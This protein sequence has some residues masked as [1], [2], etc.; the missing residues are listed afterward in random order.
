MRKGAESHDATAVKVGE[1][2]NFAKEIEILHTVSDILEGEKFTISESKEAFF[3]RNPLF[4]C[5]NCSLNDL[6]SN[7]HDALLSRRAGWKSR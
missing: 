4:Q 6:Y 2:A 1:L 7:G 3:P 5:K